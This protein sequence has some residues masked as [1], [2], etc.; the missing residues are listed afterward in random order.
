[1]GTPASP[2]SIF[3]IWLLF[4]ELCLVFCGHVSRVLHRSPFPIDEFFFHIHDFHALC[5][6]PLEHVSHVQFHASHHFWWYVCFFPK[7]SLPGMFHRFGDPVRIL[8]V[9]RSIFG[10]VHHHHQLS[11][12]AALD[13]MHVV[14]AL[15]RLHGRRQVVQACTKRVFSHLQPRVRG[16]LFPFQRHGVVVGCDGILLQDTMQPSS[17]LRRRTQQEVFLLSV[18]G[19]V[20]L[21]AAWSTAHR[22][23]ATRRWF[24]FLLDGPSMHIRRND[25]GKM[26]GTG[27]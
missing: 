5:G 27:M 16:V 11:H 22:C 1:M 20:V 12:V 26:A 18:L 6:P 23:V 9:F 13:Q 3:W 15:P 4:F 17:Q 8:V 14:V 25:L 10:F 19:E 24:G 7:V 21:S 2:F